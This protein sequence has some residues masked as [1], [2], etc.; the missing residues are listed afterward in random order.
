MPAALGQQDETTVGDVEHPVLRRLHRYW[1]EKRGDRA[2]PSRA[3]IDPTEIPTLLPHVLLV[4]ALDQGSKFRFR[5]VGTAVAQGTDPTGAF[6]HDAAPKGPYG[7]HINALYARAA[8]LAVPFYTEF[9]YGHSDRGGP[10]SIHRLFLPLS[11]QEQD[12][13]ML[14]VGQIAESPA[15]ISR[16]AWQ[17]PPQKFR[18]KHLVVVDVPTL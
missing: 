14:L 3:D 18:P 12:I 11:E 16:S 10:Q 2:N 1:L 9:C 7:Q 6:L 5:L 13:N 15:E 17:L 4:D 8:R